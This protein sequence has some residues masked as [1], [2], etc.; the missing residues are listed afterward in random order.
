MNA[1]GFNTDCRTSIAA[2]NIS[3][4]D[5]FEPDTPLMSFLEG[6]DRYVLDCLTNMPQMALDGEEWK[7]LEQN[8]GEP[9]IYFQSFEWCYQWCKNFALCGD[10]NSQPDLQIFTLRKNGELALVW[11]LMIVKSRFGFR[12]LTFLSE[13]HGQ[14]GNIIVN[15]QLISTEIGKKIWSHVRKF[16]NADAIT[17]DQY[18]K[19]SLLKEIIDGS[20]T[21]EKSIKHSSILDLNAFETW[22]E[23]KASLGRKVRKYRNQRRNK[24]NKQ[25]KVEYNVVFGGSAQYRDLVELSMKWKRIWLHE[26]GRRA[27]VFSQNRTKNFLLN[28]SGVEGDDI[29][30]P[31]GAV[32]GVLSLDDVPIGIEIGMCLDGHYYCY[33]GAFDWQWR[34]LSVGKIQIEEM[35]IW[36]KQ[37]GLN[38]FDFLGDP[39]EYKTSWTNTTDA[40]ESRFIPL[41]MRGFFY[42]V[43]WKTYL[44][45]ASRI[46][47]NKLNA[48]NRSKLLK[49]L[50]M[51]EKNADV[52]SIAKPDVKTENSELVG[53]KSKGVEQHG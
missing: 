37:V 21:I 24:L 34:K 45:P 16:S 51:R 46:I 27:T 41:T 9:Y 43:V 17:F 13:P 19:S 33:L 52:N 12:K 4:K 11:P 50:G 2:M 49:L 44:R 53:T 42:S 1:Q 8:C 31:K 39:A 28:L 30:P 15:R 35:Q 26:T 36:A 48:S 3:D 23:Y 40:L 29:T 38:K 32:L 22:D 18:P 5:V 25:G 6:A 7:S 14:Y 10:V 47:F 20:G